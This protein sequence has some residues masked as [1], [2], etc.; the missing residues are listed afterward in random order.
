MCGPVIGAL[1]DVDAVDLL[2]LSVDVV[3]VMIEVVGD[4]D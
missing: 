3:F 4:D 1:S 2:S